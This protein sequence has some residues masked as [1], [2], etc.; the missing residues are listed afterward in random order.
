M[1][2]VTFSTNLDKNHPVSLTLAN[3]EKK[4][5]F[6]GIYFQKN[7]NVVQTQIHTLQNH[8]LSS[9]T[10]HLDLYSFLK[11]FSLEVIQLLYDIF[12]SF[13]CSLENHEI[14]LMFASFIFGIK[15]LLTLFFPSYSLNLLSVNY[16]F[17]RFRLSLNKILLENKLININSNK[18]PSL[19]N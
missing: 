17:N 13:S 1:Q 3:L 12:G 7:P 2:N 16:I 5:H 19:K 18:K 14:G 4:V 10:A 6:Q 11:I 9:T 8:V 15:G